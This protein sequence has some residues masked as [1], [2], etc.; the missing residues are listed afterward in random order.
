MATT[1]FAVRQFFALP[2]PQPPIE[3]GTPSGTFIVT[4]SAPTPSSGLLINDNRTNLSENIVDISGIEY[5][6]TSSLGWFPGP[7]TANSQYVIIVGGNPSFA[8]T[9]ADSRAGGSKIS[10]WGATGSAN[11]QAEYNTAFI[12]LAKQIRDEFDLA[13]QYPDFTTVADAKA[14]CQNEGFYY[15]YPV[16]LEGQSPRT[17]DGSDV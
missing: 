14:F 3:G 7:P 13:G 16:G 2:N 15:Q 12:A 9:T 8:N 17:G 1:T 6:G 4:G 5:S 10:C 11:T